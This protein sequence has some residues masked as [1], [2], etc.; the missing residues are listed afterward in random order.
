[1]SSPPPYE[2]PSGQYGQNPYGQNP[3]GYGSPPP[4]Y[5]GQPL[6]YGRPPAR[7]GLAIT[8]L[9]LGILALVTCWLT[10][11]GIILGILAVIFG[12]V[13]L[14]RARTDRVSNKG[15]AI[16]GLITGVVGAV[17]G[18]VLLFV[19]IR[20]ASDCQDQYGSNITEEQLQRCIED[21]L[22]G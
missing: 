19:G 5:P 17:I 11:P 3:Y 10:F 8:S 14:A 22:G 12:G 18:T 16:A 6:G 4:G 13:A 7:N 15:M 9:V 20:I 21:N 2:Q 1:M